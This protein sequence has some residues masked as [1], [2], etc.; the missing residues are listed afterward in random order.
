MVRWEI[1]KFFGNNDFELW[2][3]KMQEILNSEALMP[4]GLTH[5]HKNEM[6]DKARSVII[7]L[8]LKQQL[9]SFRMV[10]NKFMV[11]QLT[12]FQKIIDDLGN[13]EVKINDE[14]KVLLL[15]SSLSRSFKHFKDV[16]LYSKEGTVTFNEV[17]TMVKSK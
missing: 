8:Y 6:L 14:D 2:K 5:V 9:Y 13:I 16:L 10:E 17:Q 15:L 4:V 12:E 1:E 3:I 7:L 11:E